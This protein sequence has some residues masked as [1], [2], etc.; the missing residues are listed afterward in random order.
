M[1]IK[2]EQKI[3]NIRERGTK[4]SPNVM[5]CRVPYEA[6]QNSKSEKEE[7]PKLQMEGESGRGIKGLGNPLD[8]TDWPV[9]GDVDQKKKRKA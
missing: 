6:H 8:Q 9:G 4:Y 2:P 7:R 5:T 1:R 3:E